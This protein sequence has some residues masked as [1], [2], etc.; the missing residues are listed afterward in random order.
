MASTHAARTAGTRAAASPSRSSANVSTTITRSA[1]RSGWRWLTQM[2]SRRA[3][4][5]QFTARRRS[6]GAYGRTSANSSA[7][8][9]D[10]GPGGCRRRRAGS[11]ACSRARVD[12]RPGQDP[13]RHRRADGALPP[14]QAERPVDPHPDRAEG[15][16]APGRR[17]Q[18]ELE[19]RRQ[20]RARCRS[21][22]ARRGRAPRRSTAPAV[23]TSTSTQA[24]GAAPSSRSTVPVDDVAFD[25][26]VGVEGEAGRDRRAARPGP[27]RPGTAGRTARRRRPARPAR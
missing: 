23:G 4:T 18:P 3:L 21:T 14:H 5:D 17:A 24:R 9:P 26:P 13:Q 22:P 12:A 19:Q 27:R 20:R 11:A 15:D 10:R 2:P 7:V 1:E 6:P 8:A 25:H 16:Q